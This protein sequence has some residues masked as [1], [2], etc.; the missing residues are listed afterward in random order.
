MM[1]RVLELCREFAQ[2]GSP[3]VGYP[4]AAAAVIFGFIFAIRFGMPVA[5]IA[6]ALG[7]IYIVFRTLTYLN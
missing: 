1:E 3:A 7:L 4:V 5:W 2:M 6:V